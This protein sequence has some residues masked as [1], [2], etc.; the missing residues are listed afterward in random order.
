MQVKNVISASRRRKM[1]PWL[2]IAPALIMNIFVVLSPTLG[3]LILSLTDWNGFATPHFVGINNYK[4]L[5]ADPVFWRAI[6]NNA[7][8]LAVFTTVPSILAL[9]VANIMR[10]LK[11]S[12]MFFRSAYFMPNV[13][14]T[15]VT[16]RVWMLIFSPMFGINYVLG[17]IGITG[18][19]NWLSDHRF[20]LLSVIS[21][22]VWQYWGFLMV[23]FLTAMQQADIE[24]EE[25]ARIDGA[26]GFQLFWRILVPQLRPTIM[27]M[28]MLS[29]IWSMSAFD[30]VYVMTNGGPGRTTE[31]LATYMY[32][33]AMYN[34]TSGYASTIAL[35]MAVFSIVILSVFNILK[36]KGWDI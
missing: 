17:K 4:R 24:L 25:A 32:K 36:K 19:P 3:T 11:K 7:I 9:V 12:Q 27:T 21:V 14:S 13:I 2:F 26:N 6:S 22:N 20:T 33:L 34:N 10:S 15:L 5:F 18:L 8:W 28:L 35:T 31:L 1:L 30:Y 16:A 23:L 29:M